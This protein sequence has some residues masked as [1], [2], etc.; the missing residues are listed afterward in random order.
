[1]FLTC[2][3]RVR[4][5]ILCNQCIFIPF[6]RRFLGGSIYW[7]PSIICFSSLVQESATVTCYARQRTVLGT[8][9]VLIDEPGTEI[10]MISFRVKILPLI[11][12]FALQKQVNPNSRPN[13]FRG[14]VGRSV[15][16]TVLVKQLQAQMVTCRALVRMEMDGHEGRGTGHG[17]NRKE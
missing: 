3:R 2:G 13:R 4:S 1:M 9:R 10:E 11:F 16:E 12:F 17:D 6:V 5:S 14:S 15:S 8:S 7:Q